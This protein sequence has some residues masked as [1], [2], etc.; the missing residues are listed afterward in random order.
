MHRS[1]IRDVK[2]TQAFKAEFRY[3]TPT[4]V[5]ATDHVGLPAME[6]EEIHVWL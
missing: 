2:F 6:E 1:E 4:A 5:R 3:Q